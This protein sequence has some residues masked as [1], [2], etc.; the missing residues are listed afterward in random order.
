MGCRV[1]RFHI[2][3]PA[4]GA[5]AVRLEPIPMLS[6][7]A[8]SALGF[9]IIAMLLLLVRSAVRAWRTGSLQ[10]IQVSSQW[11]NEHKARDIS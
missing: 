2:R 8:V 7:N 10:E 1:P 11:L 4:P 5:M 6:T 9:V 3:C